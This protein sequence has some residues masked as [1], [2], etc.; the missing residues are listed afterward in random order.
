MTISPP[1]S[2][3]LSDEAAYI[4]GPTVPVNGGLFIGY[5]GLGSHRQF[6]PGADESAV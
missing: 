3:L 1:P 5:R 2:Y 6:G 4:A